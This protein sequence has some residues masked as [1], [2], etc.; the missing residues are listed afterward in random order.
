MS[1]GRAAAR[2]WLMWNLVAM[3]TDSKPKG[4]LTEP[5]VVASETAQYKSCPL[6]GLRQPY[7]EI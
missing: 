6:C 4:R 5:S 2:H 3:W 1:P 7:L